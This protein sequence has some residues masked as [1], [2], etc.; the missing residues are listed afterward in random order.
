[1]GRPPKS[2]TIDQ[3]IDRLWTSEVKRTQG[4]RE[5]PTAVRVWKLLHGNEWADPSRSNQIVSLSYVEKRVRKLKS[6]GGNL[7]S[8]ESWQP[9]ADPQESAE[10]R[11]YLLKLNAIKQAEL[12]LGLLQHQAKWARMLRVALEGLSLYQ[13]YCLVMMYGYRQF[14]ADYL[15][16]NSPYTTDLDSFVAYR[17]WLPGNQ[18]PYEAAVAMGLAPFPFFMPYEM[19]DPVGAK[20]SGAAL[21]LVLGHIAEHPEALRGWSK[22]ILES[23]TARAEGTAE[24]EAGEAKAQMRNTVWKFWADQSTIE[25]KGDR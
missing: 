22:M 13:Q 18:H 2:E 23:I 19:E 25:E 1:M 4:T 9:W 17:P 5:K 16:K 15:G 10:E 7:P 8:Y 12:D 11:A 3:K 21:F 24:A 14:T 6:T 20:I